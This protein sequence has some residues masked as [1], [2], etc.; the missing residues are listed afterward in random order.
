M[1]FG[2]RLSEDAQTRS[3]YDNYQM[4]LEVVKKGMEQNAL[5]TGSLENRRRFAA[6][7]FETSAFGKQLA[8][9][10]GKAVIV[11]DLDMDIHG[12]SC[13]TLRN[14]Q[15]KTS[16]AMSVQSCSRGDEAAARFDLDD[17]AEDLTDLCMR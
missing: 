16:K 9:Y 8:E 10:T 5:H 13:I 17:S 1:N 2:K 6:I 4:Q 11:P 3:T 14:Y 15:P 7:F 12:N